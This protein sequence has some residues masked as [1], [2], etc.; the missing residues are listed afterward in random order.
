MT[1]IVANTGLNYVASMIGTD[2]DYKFVTLL[3]NYT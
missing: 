3:Y 2:A 1:G